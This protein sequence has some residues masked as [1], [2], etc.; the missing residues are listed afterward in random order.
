MTTSYS[1]ATQVLF[2]RALA[3]VRTLPDN[4]TIQLTPSERLN[5]YG[6][7]K[8]ATQGDCNQPRPSSRDGAESAKWKAWDRLQGLCPTD[9]QTFY[10]EALVELIGEFIKTYPHHP[11]VDSLSESL[12]YLEQ[13][14][15]D[16]Q[17]HLVEPTDREEEYYLGPIQSPLDNYSLPR[18]YA[19]S[20]PSLLTTTSHSTQEYPMTPDLS[21][22]YQK[23]HRYPKRYVQPM[24]FLYQPNDASDTD[25]IDRE[26]AAITAPLALSSPDYHPYQKPSSSSSARPKN[27]NNSN[28]N[29]GLTNHRSRP[30]ITERAM[31]KLQTEV[32][33]LAEQLAILR[34]QQA[35]RD[36]RKRQLRWSWLWLGKTV[37][38]HTLV[39]TI[40]FLVLFLIMWRQG[41]PWAHKILQHVGGGTQKMMRSL[42]RRAIL[43][44]AT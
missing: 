9:A 16:G 23:I 10:V 29:N 11:N 38:K 32:T 42:V 12:N 3:V 27:S 26:V 30:D 33:G 24:D 35:E 39:D 20:E 36:T 40:I 14:S 15:D 7:Y 4:D 25:T 6:L 31:E 19:L 37:L 21:P 43:W 34:R 44:R 22:S 8:Q 18:H 2:C 41:S 1:Y 28:N 13:P 17:E 5:L